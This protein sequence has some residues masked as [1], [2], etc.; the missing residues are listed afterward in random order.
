MQQRRR[1][2]ALL[3]LPLLSACWGNPVDQAPECVAW[4]ACTR[5][6]DDA[7]TP[8]D[9]SRFLDGGFCWNNPSLAEGCTTACVRG[10]ER[11]RVRETSLPVECAP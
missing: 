8:L 2:R 10:L 3:L 4:V 6:L 9:L 7:F 1:M 11:L 5:A